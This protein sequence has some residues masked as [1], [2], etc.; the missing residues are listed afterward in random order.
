MIR[1]AGVLIVC[2]QRGEVFLCFRTKPPFAWSMVGGMVER[3]ES[4]PEA[5]IREATEELGGLPPGRV[6]DH[7]SYGDGG[8]NHFLTL[9]YDVTP[10]TR[11]TW[12]P[13]LDW[14]HNA[15]GWFPFST[16]PEPLHPGAHYTLQ[17]SVSLP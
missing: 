4:F 8:G 5:A 6:I 12:N 13:R 1:A 2:R 3:A 17:N 14:E 16:L 7:V 11:L 15:C 9:V 10:A